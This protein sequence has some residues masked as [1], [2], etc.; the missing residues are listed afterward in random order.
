M[1]EADGDAP[2]EDWKIFEAT[3]DISEAR[4][5]RSGSRRLSYASSSGSIT[6]VNRSSLVTHHADDTIDTGAVQPEIAFEV[7]AG[8]RYVDGQGKLP[9]CAC[10]PPR[11]GLTSTGLWTM[12][13]S[14]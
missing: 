10:D 11:T 3:T 14:P 5:C 1:A 13:C 2:P 4:L 12:L 7:F 9:S 6:G 8:R